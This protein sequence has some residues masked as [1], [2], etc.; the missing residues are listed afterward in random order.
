M[1]DKILQQLK[2]IHLDAFSSGQK[3]D[4]WHYKSGD[5]HGNGSRSREIESRRIELCLKTLSVSNDYV[6]WP[7]ILCIHNMKMRKFMEKIESLHFLENGSPEQL[8]L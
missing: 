3:I 8:A 2:P 1:E 7:Y 4:T 6:K 5:L